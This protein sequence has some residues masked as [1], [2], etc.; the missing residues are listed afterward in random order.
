MQLA[1]IEFVHTWTNTDIIG[2]H[3]IEFF[4]TY[5]IRIQS[6]NIV[7]TLE[8]MSHFLLHVLTLARALVRSY[9]ELR[10]LPQYVRESEPAQPSFKHP[11]SAAI[12]NC[13]THKHTQCSYYSIILCVDNSD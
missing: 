6:I 4:F 5:Y 8:A 2:R 11:S 13:A 9:P 3:S 7:H 10:A 12:R 1:V